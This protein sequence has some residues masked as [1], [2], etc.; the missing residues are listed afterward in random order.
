[1]TVHTSGG[2]YSD[3]YTEEGYK[4]PTAYKA[5]MNYKNGDIVAFE[6]NSGEREAV[7]L[8]CFDGF[9][10]AVALADEEHERD[11]KIISTALKHADCGRLMTIYYSRVTRYVKTMEV[12]A[13]KSLL[14]HIGATIGTNE[15]QVV[16]KIVTKEV[17]KEAKDDTET[18]IRIAKLE[19]ERDLYKQLY[20]EAL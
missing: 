18:I 7:L 9:A 12:E 1:M 8:A 20:K 4:D 11:H 2:R 17:A 14:K 3:Y 13:F 5:M 19:A 6:T 15:P 10:T 16:E